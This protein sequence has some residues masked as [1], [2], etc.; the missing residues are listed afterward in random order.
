MILPK[1]TYLISNRDPS[2]PNNYIG[3]VTYQTAPNN[4]QRPYLSTPFKVVPG[5]AW[6][7]ALA[8][9]LETRYA[10]SSDVWDIAFYIHGYATSERYAQLGLESYGLLLS[11]V[12]FDRGI[13][14]GVSWPSSTWTY[15]GAQTNAAASKALLSA[16]GQVVTRLRAN[17]G[18][19]PVRATIFCHSMG[20]Y[21]LSMSLV[22]GA[23]LPSIDSIFLLAA[24]VDYALWDRT[25]TSYPQ[26]VAVAKAAGHAYVLY[27]PNDRVLGDSGWV[28]WAYRLGYYGAKSAAQLPKNVSQLDYSAWGNDPY[29]LDYV[30][31]SYYNTL[32]G[33]G[34]LVHSSSKFVPDLIS[35]QNHALRNVPQS[36][37]NVPAARDLARLVSLV[38]VPWTPGKSVARK[39]AP[40]KKG[41][42]VKRVK[43]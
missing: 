34:A 12:G 42:G 32:A 7:H 27:T 37:L 3:P 14:V 38:S 16:C 22:N 43:G 17:I 4:N 40:A 2:D 18:R 39:S 28:N 29:C 6:N 33:T 8:A 19:R 25:S 11:S 30:P 26:G 10:G 20:N 13:L 24:D 36:S 21:L 15:G 9:D 5:D 41:A 1:Y 31:Y 23:T 35:F